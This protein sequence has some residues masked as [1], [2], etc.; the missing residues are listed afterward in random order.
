[1]TT[2]TTIPTTTTKMTK[3]DRAYQKATL[4]KYRGSTGVVPSLQ[5]ISLWSGTSV[6]TASKF[7]SGNSPSKEI[8]ALIRLRA[9]KNLD[10]IPDDLLKL[11]DIWDRDEAIS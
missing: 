10:P 9:K 3:E 4:A 5:D 2:T 8:R 11:F 7:V 1:M 6:G